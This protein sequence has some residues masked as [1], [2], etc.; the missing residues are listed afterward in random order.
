MWKSLALCC[1]GLLATLSVVCKAAD[2]SIIPKPQQL[3]VDKGSYVLD[4]RTTIVA[5][6]GARAR[7]IA[8]FLR[9]A[10]QEQTGI[11]LSHGKS[12]HAIVLKMDPSV[13]G[14]EAYRLS[15]TTRHVTI[16]ACSGG[17]R[18]CASC[19]RFG[20]RPERI[21]RRCISRMRRAF[22]GAG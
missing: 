2:I 9:E 21:F 20:M 17:C 11:R 8:S 12:A 14:D 18:H 22:H 13:H 16:K 6:G 19:C 5:P 4:A 1:L 7:E 15:V 3:Q 10:I